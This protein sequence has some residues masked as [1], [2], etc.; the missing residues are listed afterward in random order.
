LAL[1]R[2]SWEAPTPSGWDVLRLDVDLVGA[3]V[4]AF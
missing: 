3:S 2:G 4:E 1:G